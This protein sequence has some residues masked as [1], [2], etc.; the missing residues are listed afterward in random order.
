MK[1]SAA[2]LT[3]LLCC[4]V[5]ASLFAQGQIIWNNTSSTLIS[6]NGGAMPANN[7]VSP[8]TTYNFGLFVAPPGT[9]APSGIDDPNWQY[10]A[11]YAM[12]STASAG[13]GRMQN[14][15]TA[16]VNGFAMGTT[17]NFIVRVW[18]STSGGADWEAAKPGLT[19]YGQ[20]AL[21]TAT[22]GGG[23][24]PVPSAFGPAAGQIRG[25]DI[26]CLSCGYFPRFTV[27]PSSK[28]VTVGSD[29]TLAALATSDADCCYP[30]GYAWRKNGV[31]INDAGSSSLTLLN[32]QIIDAGNYD[33]MAY[34]GFGTAYSGVATLTVIAPA[35]T[36]TLGS[37]DYTANHQFQFTVTGTA[38]SNYVVQVATNLSAPTTWASL[39]TNTSPFTFVDSTAQNSP[40]RFYRAL[41]R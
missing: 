8:S 21:G 22:L 5:T 38:G 7:P 16:T 3:C 32:V 2:C 11:A 14:P 12:N 20:S 18:Q 23:P 1:T 28:S 40:R 41:A 35:I 27:N 25:F 34:N 37:P 4:A 33:V 29:V 6:V 15:G 24:I 10:V 31:I 17:V 30:M 39:L 36:A 19:L 26:V 9:P 13:A